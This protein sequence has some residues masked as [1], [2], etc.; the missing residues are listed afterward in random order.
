[1]QGQIQKF[2]QGGVQSVQG[3]LYILTMV[4]KE[5]QNRDHAIGEYW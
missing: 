4:A 3:G 5:M 1:M 2:L